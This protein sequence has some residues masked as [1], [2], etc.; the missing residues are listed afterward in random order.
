[1]NEKHHPLTLAEILDRTAYIY[2]SRFLV[3]FGIGVIPAGTV[4]VFFA[5]FVLFFAWIGSSDSSKLALTAGNILACFFVGLIGLLAIPVCLGAAA[6]GWVAISRAAAQAYLGEK[7]GIR[8]AYRYGWKHHWRY[9]WLYSLVVLLVAVAPIAVF[10]LGAP[11]A[12]ALILLGGRTGIGAANGIIGGAMFLLFAALAVYA[13]WMLLRLCLAFPA[14]V[15]EQSTAWK[16]LKRSAALSKGTKGRMILLYLL[17]AALSWLLA[18]GFLV[19]MG[20][21]LAMIPGINDPQHAQTLGMVLMFTW[22][23]LLFLVQALTKPVYG[24][25]LTLFYFDQ[26]IRM[27]GFDI[28]WMMQQAGMIVALPTTLEA[29]P[30]TAPDPL[31][32]GVSQS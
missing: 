26:R 3:F 21:L 28:E 22:Y 9:V 15:V 4:L 16:A 8:D 29:V 27:E 5:G 14:C 32:P 18:L 30:P 24:I 31:V 6:L 17:G 12:D 1:M 10:A 7:F 25:A 2:R 19:P 11:V 13:V 23:G 20:I